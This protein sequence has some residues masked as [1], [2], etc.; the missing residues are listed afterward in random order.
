MVPGGSAEPMP[1]M[2]FLVQSG[3]S[4][5]QGGPGGVGDLLERG[6]G[7]L[8][9]LGWQGHVAVGGCRAAVL[10]A[11]KISCAAQNAWSSLDWRVP[12]WLLWPCAGE[13]PDGAGGS[14]GGL[15]CRAGDDSRRDL[16]GGAAAA[17]SGQRAGCAR[18]GRDPDQ[19][20]VQRGCHT[21]RAVPVLAAGADRWSP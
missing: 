17:V 16:G 8:L 21:R 6:A 7:E 4:A 19:S 20:A 13:W 15:P 9:D 2:V 11:V 18:P 5:Q 1:P 10:L 12:A 14:G 3:C